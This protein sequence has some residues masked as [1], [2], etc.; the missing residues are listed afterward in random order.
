[1]TRV[2]SATGVGDL[3]V[4]FTDDE[5][6]GHFVTLRN[7]L[8]AP[9]AIS[10]LLSI[11]QAVKGGCTHGVD[12]DGGWLRL[13]EPIGKYVFADEEQGLYIV[14]AK[15]QLASPAVISLSA[16]T[17]NKTEGTPTKEQV[18]RLALQIHASLGH[19]HWQGVKSLLEGGAIP[20]LSKIPN[21]MKGL[22]LSLSKLPCTS[23][24][25]AKKTL[26]S[27]PHTSLS[28]PKLPKKPWQL[29]LGDHCGPFSVQ[30]GGNTYYSL[31]I[32]DCHDVGFI[33]ERSLLTGE[34][35]SADCR[36]HGSQILRWSGEPQD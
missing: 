27:L 29:L 3:P 24:D 20:Q 8:W 26:K 35:S 32:E 36:Q 25:L 34:G 28:L 4:T 16:N 13:P 5:D 7:V 33:F 15:L 9:Q 31:L 19:L 18:E 30:Y 2:A 14:D 23:C 10:S 1:M 11:S 21:K 6:D 22:L 12:E 17:S